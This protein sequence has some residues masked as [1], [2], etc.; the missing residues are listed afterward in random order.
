[1]SEVPRRAN[2]A[3]SRVQDLERHGAV[4]RWSH[5]PPIARSS[6]SLHHG[7]RAQGWHDLLPVGEEHLLLSV[8]YQAD[9]P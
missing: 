5:R 7:L 9:P 2:G 1:M 8:A 6:R 3:H 4:P